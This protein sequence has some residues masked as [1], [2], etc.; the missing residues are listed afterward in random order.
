MSP[1]AISAK[2]SST[3]LRIFLSIFGSIFLIVGLVAF[4][5][6]FVSPR[7][8]AHQANEWPETKCKILSSKLKVHSG[9][10]N[11]SYEPI[12]KF[13]YEVDNKKWVGDQASFNPITSTQRFANELVQK[14][15]AGST[16][17]CFFNPDDPSDSVLSKELY[18]EFFLNLLPL[19]FVAAGATIL[20][21]GIFGWG[22]KDKTTVSAKAKARS[23]S[24]LTP[25]SRDFNSPLTATSPAQHPADILDQ[26]WSVPK[27]LKP[28][29]TKW[30]NLL[31]ITFAALLWNGIVSI[32]V[33]SAIGKN[34]DGF[35]WFTLIFMIPFTL[36]GLLFVLAIVYAILALFNPDVEIA[37][38]SGAIALGE[39]VDIA[40][41]V[42]GN[43]SRIK[44]LTLEFKAE[45]I[46]TY[47]QGTNTYTDRELFEVIPIVKTSDQGEMQFGSATI[48][49]PESTM[50]TFKS[51]HNE[52]AWSVS[53][54]GDIPKWPNVRAFHQFRVKPA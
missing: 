15:K 5:F 19:I 40:W 23:T 21:W 27:K 53:V 6:Y 35:D 54:I 38:S 25:A 4:W 42:K 32:F 13:E 41:E 17:V 37:M 46:S 50:H 2:K 10:E 31:G 1:K 3:P 44:T 22:M 30:T 12:I 9:D 49:I 26:E 52:I 33:F 29:S 18:P 48:T 34:M 14:F 39:S 7:L 20:S 24:R 47:Q 8:K 45:Q 36:I 16:A 51:N 43:T 11:D 28:K